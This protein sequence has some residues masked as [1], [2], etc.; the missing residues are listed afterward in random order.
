MIKNWTNKVVVIA[1]DE[2]INYLYIKA[3]LKPTNAKIIW[4]KTGQETIDLCES[5]KI[6]IVLMDVKMPEVDGLEATMEIK[7]SLPNLPIIAQTAYAMDEDKHAS[8]EAGCNDFITKPISPNLL[9]N[10]M[11]KYI[12][13]Y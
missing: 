6:D 5:E 7:K 13:V 9:L 12:D 8:I 2:Q 10:V 1:E 3:A 11:S 4:T